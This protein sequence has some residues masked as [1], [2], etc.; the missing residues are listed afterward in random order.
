VPP[1]SQKL[2]LPCWNKQGTM[3]TATQGIF[4]ALSKGLESCLI[5]KSMIGIDTARCLRGRYLKIYLVGSR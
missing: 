1:L 2:Q 4:A 5:L 3:S